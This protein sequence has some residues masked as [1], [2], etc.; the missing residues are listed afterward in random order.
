MVHKR[1]SAATS[2]ER[3]HCITAF[4]RPAG[5]CPQVVVLALQQVEPGQVIRAAEMRL[6]GFAQ[7]YKVQMAE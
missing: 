1:R 7:P 3:V 5:R 2:L 6:R 4:D